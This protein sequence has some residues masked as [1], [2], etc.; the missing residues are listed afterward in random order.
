VDDVA[1]RANHAL[2]EKWTPV[3]AA[4]PGYDVEAFKRG[5]IRLSDEEIAGVG[6]VAGKDLLHI[7]CHFGL[8]TLSWA[9]LGARVTGADF[10]ESAVALARSIAGELEIDA[11]FVVSSVDDLPSR[12]AGD[13]D[14]VYT[15]K[16]VL[17]W[18]PDIRAWAR[19]VSHF[20]RP[21][22]TFYI[23]EI[24]PV[25]ESFENEDVAPGELRLAYPYWEHSD[26]IVFPVRGTYA[27]P[28]STEDF[29]TGYGW[30][31]GLGEIVTA[32]IDAGLTIEALREYPF[33]EWRLD[34]L[35][36]G[37]DG[38]SRLPGDLDGRLPLSFSLRAT[39]PAR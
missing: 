29:G 2:W 32:L 28:N 34:N 37:P 15:G 18:L 33:T 26:P 11:T 23:F 10:S 27:D 39:K 13:F 12:L 30:N 8:D 3:H 19:V 9:R 24:H 20:V 14:V 7:Q 21:G 22:G 16:G 31:H 38:R 5:G 35:V 4:S 25:M 1:R 6:P 17:G 36:E